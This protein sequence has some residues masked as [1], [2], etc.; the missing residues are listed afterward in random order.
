MMPLRES[1]AGKRNDNINKQE[2]SYAMVDSIGHCHSRRNCNPCGLLWL[3]VFPGPSKIPQ[4]MG[5]GLGD[6]FFSV[7]VHAR[8]AGLAEKC[9]SAHGQ[10]GGKPFKRG[11]SLVWVL[12]V[13]WQTVS[14]TFYL[15]VRGGHPV[16]FDQHPEPVFFSGHV[17]ADLCFPGLCLY[18][19]RDNFFK[20][21]FVG[22]KGSCRRWPRIHHLGYP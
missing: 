13:H 19:D 21:V 22:K 6:L 11:S 4:D 7:C 3:C 17:S 20:I 14:P 18:P 2:A 16:D 5:H 10:S 15:S 8:Y 9:F 12:S 1:T